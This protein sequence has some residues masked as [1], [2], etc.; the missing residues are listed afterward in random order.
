MD[1][2]FKGIVN[3]IHFKRGEIIAFIPQA[4]KKILIDIFTGIKSFRGLN[5]EAQDKLLNIIAKAKGGFA[6][7]GHMYNGE[8]LIADWIEFNRNEEIDLFMKQYY[9][10]EEY[11]EN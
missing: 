7:E 8:L 5:L 3:W 11:D 10:C 1:V 9:S 6:A 2:N 4:N